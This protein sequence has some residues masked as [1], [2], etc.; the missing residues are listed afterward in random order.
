MRRGL[1]SLFVRR[2]LSPRDS[3]SVFQKKTCEEKKIAFS[4]DHGGMVTMYVCGPTVYDAAHLGH[5]RTYVQLDAIRSVLSKVC[6]SQVAYFMNVTDVDDKI[7]NRAREMNVC[8][9]DLAERN[10]EAFFKDMDE[11]GVERPT[12]APR[13]TA[14]IPEMI[15]YIKKLEKKGLAYRGAVSG[16]VYFDTRKYNQEISDKELAYGM[17]E[18]NRSFTDHNQENPILGDKKSMQDF[19]LWKCVNG[20][21]NE[22][23]ESHFGPGRPGWHT[24]CAVMIEH[25]AGMIRGDG[26]LDIHG[27]GQDL[28]FPHHENERVQGQMCCA[29]GKDWTQYFIHTGHLHIEGRKMSKSLKNFIT[30]REMLDGKAVGYPR[31]TGRQIRILFLMLKYNTDLELNQKLVLD[32]IQFDEKIQDLASKITVLQDSI[33]SLKWCKDDIKLLEAGDVFNRNFIGALLDD[34]DTPVALQS[35]REIVR[36]CLQYIASAAPKKSVVLQVFQSVV[37]NLQLINVKGF[38]EEEISRQD[39][40]L[41]E[42]EEFVDTAVQMRSEIRRAAKEKDFAKVFEICDRYRDE[43]FSKKGVVISDDVG[44]GSGS[45]WIFKEYIAPTHE[46]MK[47]Q[48]GKFW[49]IPPSQLFQVHPT[50]AGKYSE[51]DQDGLPTHHADGAELTKTARKK[52]RKKQLYHA[53]KHSNV[54]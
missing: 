52:L 13:A 7:L 9:H 3:V 48:G 16:S 26:R 46:P 1:S 45:S 24:E 53:K 5:A 54:A 50:H 10:I 15:E 22:T 20:H 28:K 32:A 47:P 39:P 11:L 36:H 44:S 19:A 29:P 30:I 2:R 43:V 34:F 25:T 31:M 18:R 41:S 40:F 4:L 6:G 12:F 42:K 23:W 21:E 51:F 38:N 14:Y 17:L 8:W 35:T 33:S 37:Q 49:D 27:G